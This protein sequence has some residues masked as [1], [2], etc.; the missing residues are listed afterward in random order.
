[1][2]FAAGILPFHVVGQTVSPPAIEWQRSF[3]GTNWQQPF[4]VRQTSDG[5]FIVGG[6]ALPGLGG[7]KTSAGFGESDF[8]VVRLDRGG[9]KLW[10]GSF[11]GDQSDVLV[12]LEQTADD[13][14]ILV[15]WSYSPSSGN[16]SSPNLGGGSDGWVV[17]LD[18]NGNK[19]WDRSYS[20]TNYEWLKSV[21]KTRDGGFVLA[22]EIGSM[23][24]PSDFWILWIDADGNVIR[25][26]TFGGT[27]IEVDPSIRP[28]PDG[29][30]VIA[31][32]TTSPPSGNK[33]S[34]LPGG[35]VDSWLVRLDRNGGKLWD[36]SFG[37]SGD[38]QRAAV[39]STADGG[40]VMAITSPSPASGNKTSEG[41]GWDDIWVVRTDAAGDKLWEQSLGGT[42]EEVAGRILQ[43]A[44]GGFII[45][46]A[47]AS[48]TN[49][50]KTSPFFGGPTSLWQQGDFWLARLDA[51]GNK[52]WDQS[53][54]GSGS[55][56]IE[57]L[58]Q[59]SDGGFIL[60]GISRSAADGNKTT[61]Q[62]ARAD[63]WVIK[64]AP[65]ALSM[66]PRLRPV[67]QT[68]EDIQRLGYRFVLDGRSNLNCVVEHSIDLVSWTPFQTNRLA[69]PNLEI[70]D[71][72]ATGSS[73]RFYRARVVP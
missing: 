38:E 9:N 43:T 25:E 28:T 42:L 50:N 21:S 66:P 64:L 56:G 49:G 62:F 10:D 60:A 16:K 69:L 40:F 46:G 67:Q 33:T 54:G 55:D 17:R 39:D 70:V 13:G 34:P 63:F 14:F 53:F 8:W 15:G 32:V 26:Q 2:I 29:G 41:F 12:D 72:S 11:G 37:G 36:R 57:S 51:D 59:T 71:T 31:G 7:N 61:E 30:Y 22:G 20:S 44:D 24:T 23:Y 65:D 68:F 27:R 47:S 18:A 73:S 45:G 48:G 1:M 19:L 4:C 35:G 58:A 5:G 52:L 6:I 3:G